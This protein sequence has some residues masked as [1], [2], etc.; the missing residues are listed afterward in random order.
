MAK[1]AI[2]IYPVYISWKLNTTMMPDYVPLKNAQIHLYNY[3][4][5]SVLLWIISDENMSMYF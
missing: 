1:K 4:D 5:C 2:W 3:I